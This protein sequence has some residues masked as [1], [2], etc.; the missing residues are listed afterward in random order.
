MRRIIVVPSGHS[1]ALAALTAKLQEQA[2]AGG[3]EIEVIEAASAGD[4]L[5]LPRPN[6]LDLRQGDRVQVMYESAPLQASEAASLR[7]VPLAFTARGP[8]RLGKRGKL[9]R[10]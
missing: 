9:R 4:G 3:V 7:D 1:A 5:M 6:G 2:R 10:W 8:A